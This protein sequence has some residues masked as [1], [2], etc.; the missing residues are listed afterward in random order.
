MISEVTNSLML[1][2]VAMVEMF[3]H[4]THIAPVEIPLVSFILNFL[5]ALS[6][7]YVQY[8]VI[9]GT[10]EANFVPTTYVQY[11]VTFT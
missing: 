10:L 7:Q 6:A 2:H 8:R 9:Q 5:P 11:A 1:L 4:P 3:P